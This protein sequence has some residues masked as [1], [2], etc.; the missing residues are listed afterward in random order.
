MQFVFI[1]F[2]HRSL[3]V[4]PGFIIQ[5]KSELIS[6][7]A[8]STHSDIMLVFLNPLLL[9]IMEGEKVKLEQVILLSQSASHVHVGVLITF[10]LGG[11]VLLD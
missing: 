9:L 10:F 6:L 2:F 5:S 11:I 4:K 7:A 3:T 8:P 1:F